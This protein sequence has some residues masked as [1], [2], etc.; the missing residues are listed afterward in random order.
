MDPIQQQRT[1]H[2]EIHMHYIRE[3]VHDMT[4]VLQYFPTDEK[5]VDIFTKKFTK[6][7]FTYLR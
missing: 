2:V 3:L 4:I 1:K 6:K 7:K 5:I